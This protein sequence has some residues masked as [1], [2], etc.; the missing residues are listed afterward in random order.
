MLHFRIGPVLSSVRK[1]IISGFQW[2]QEVN[3]LVKKA[4]A[5]VFISVADCS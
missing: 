5:I 1:L 4:S 2:F 3:F